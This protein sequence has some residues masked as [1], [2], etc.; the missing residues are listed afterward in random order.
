M[1]HLR[2]RASQVSSLN[3][4]ADYTHES[5]TI[6]YCLLPP[7]DQGISC[8]RFGFCE[9]LCAVSPCR[10]QTDSR[11]AISQRPARV[12]RKLAAN[13]PKQAESTRFSMFCWF[14][15]YCP[16]VLLVSTRISPCFCWLLRKL[17][18]VSDSKPSLMARSLGLPLPRLRLPQRT[19]LRP[20]GE[21]IDRERGQEAIGCGFMLFCLAL[22]FRDEGLGVSLF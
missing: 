5:W 16:H 15:P 17:A 21:Y 22:G 20:A 11:L 2:A 3:C 18:S 14:P 4:H 8:C 10:P 7:S 19:R 12:Y 1:S 13:S 9:E 6:I